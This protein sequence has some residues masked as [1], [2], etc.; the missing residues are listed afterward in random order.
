[1]ERDSLFRELG[2]LS[3]SKEWEVSAHAF[4]ATEKSAMLQRLLTAAR[5][6]LALW[7]QGQKKEW[8]TGMYEHVRRYWVEGAGVSNSRAET[9]IE[10]RKASSQKHPWS[11]AF[12]SYIM[13]KAYTGF[14]P[15][16]AHNRYI[17]WA[18]QN[19]LQNRPH[20][21]YAFRIEEVAVEVG[22]IICNARGEKELWAKYDNVES[23]PKSHGDIVIA[24]DGNIATVVGGNINKN[25]TTKKVT[26][27]PAGKVQQKTKERGPLYF[28]VIKM[29]PFGVAPVDTPQSSLAD[30]AKQFLNQTGIGLHLAVVRAIFL[31]G[32]K[33]NDLTNAI[34]HH[35]HP[36]L[37]G[38]DLGQS[39]P[40]RLK[41]EWIA[42]RNQIVR[43]FLSKY[44]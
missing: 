14:H 28:A 41:D 40:Q 26:L 32:N 34:F 24:I 44:Q 19:R 39:D 21:F 25:V 20:P 10:E 12:I 23:K 16:T 11:A 3:I 37:K 4:S 38:R 27:T 29:M 17:I 35:R 7:E 2:T 42:I 31:S 13:R 33:E 30:L 36:E 18:K 22:D 6:E 5:A 43:P 1:M 9:N 15:S 8:N